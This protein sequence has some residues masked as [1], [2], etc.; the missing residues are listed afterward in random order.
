MLDP[1]IPKQRCLKFGNDQVVEDSSGAVS[2]EISYRLVKNLSQFENT[3]K[4]SYTVDATSS[5]NL[6]G[7]INGDSTLKN[8]G[9]FENFLKKIKRAH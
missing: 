4:V 9:S 8:F 5:A 1:S 3:F 6:L 2:S 7:I